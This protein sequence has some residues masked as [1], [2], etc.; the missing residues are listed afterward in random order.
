MSAPL[1][2]FPCKAATLIQSNHTVY[3]EYSGVHWLSATVW[4]P[5]SDR[6][7]GFD[8]G[9][10][11]GRSTFFAISRTTDS[12]KIPLTVDRPIKIVASNLAI[13]SDRPI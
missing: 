13:A 7:V 12:E 9:K 1:R 11:I 2:R 10:I 8:N 4:R 3:T 6:L 5:F